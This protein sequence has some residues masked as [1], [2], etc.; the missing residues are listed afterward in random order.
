MPNHFTFAA[1]SVTF[2]VTIGTVISLRVKVTSYFTFKDITFTSES[3]PVITL[4][5]I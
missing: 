4:L 1:E 3:S 2:Y 5:Y